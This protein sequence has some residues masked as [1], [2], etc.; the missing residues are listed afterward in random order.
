MKPASILLALAAAACALNTFVWTKPGSTKADF[1]RDYAVCKAQADAGASRPL[2]SGADRAQIHNRVL[3]SCM[4]D[5]GYVPEE[6]A[7]AK[8]T[9]T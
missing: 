9:K 2:T 5:R 6:E 4:R 1:D 8:K 7:A 3:G